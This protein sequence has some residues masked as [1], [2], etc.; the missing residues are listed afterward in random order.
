MTTSAIVRELN[1]ISPSAFK[2]QEM[3]DSDGTWFVA[4]NVDR[5]PRQDHGG[6][7]DGDEWLEDYEVE[8][9]EEEYYELRIKAVNR[10]KAHFVKKGFKVDI[11]F[12]YGE[13][14]HC[15]WSLRIRK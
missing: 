4:F 7:E 3:D 13:K 14:G 15:T 12:E 5:G 2:F 1:N 6:G 11:D 8:E 10:M 9:L